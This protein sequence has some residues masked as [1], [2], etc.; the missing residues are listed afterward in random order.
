[1][2]CEVTE[3]LGVVCNV[4]I[5]SRGATATLFMGTLAAFQGESYGLEREEMSEHVPLVL[6]ARGGGEMRCDRR[7]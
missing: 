2:I 5:G 6:V 3:Q 7:V 4:Y 1:M